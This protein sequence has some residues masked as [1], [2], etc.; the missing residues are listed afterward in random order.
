MEYL[1]NIANNTAKVWALAQHNFG[2]MST[3]TLEEMAK[4]VSII[5]AMSSATYWAFMAELD[6]RQ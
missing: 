3:E 4:D 1:D 6:K 2:V 5:D